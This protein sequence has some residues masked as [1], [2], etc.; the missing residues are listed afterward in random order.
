LNRKKKKKPNAY[1]I[2]Q[3]EYYSDQFAKKY[4][5]GGA[6]SYT[7]SKATSDDIRIIAEEVFGHKYGYK[8]N[9]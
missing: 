8:A 9:G 3:Q 5:L 6:L 2:R 7:Y 1:F 4:A